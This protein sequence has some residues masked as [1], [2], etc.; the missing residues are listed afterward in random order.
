MAADT[1]DIITVA[2]FEAA[3]NIDASDPISLEEK[4]QVV[5]AASR[6][7]DQIFGPVVVRTVTGE[8]HDGGNARLWPRQTPVSSVSALAEYDHLT[9]TTL[10]AESNVLKPANAYTLQADGHYAVVYRRAT[11]SDYTFVSG[12]RNVTITYVAGRYANTAAVDRRFKEAA[13]VCAIHLFQVR[14]AGEGVS[15]GDGAPFGGVPYN[16]DTLV[17]KLKAM[18][19]DEVRPPAVA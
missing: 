9:A 2:E 15:A 5:T 12:R 10:T 16:T 14:G 8:L 1:L 17:K 6:M 7:V 11:G 3:I 13:T 18:L 4:E 19:P